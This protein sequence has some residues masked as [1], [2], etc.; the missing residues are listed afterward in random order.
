MA[1][2]SGTD[3]WSMIEYVKLDNNGCAQGDVLVKNFA[4]LKS[5]IVSKAAVTDEGAPIRGVALATI[6]SLRYGWVTIG[7]YAE[8]A[9]VSH[10][11]ASGEYLTVS[12]S[13][14]GQL[15]PNKASVFNAG[16]HGSSSMFMVVAVSHGIIA[17]SAMGSITLCG[18]WA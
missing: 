13:T 5:Y 2:K 12:G 15:T 11:S 4:T 8:N 14:A 3:Q 16:T 18:V 17:T 1:Y 10:T 6:A 7:G 9:T